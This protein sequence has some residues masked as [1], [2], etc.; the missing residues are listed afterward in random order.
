ML[1]KGIPQRASRVT[2]TVLLVA[3]GLVLG[4]AMSGLVLI[5]L[6]LIALA[7]TGLASRRSPLLR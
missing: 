6:V 7:V 4:V 3:L 5:A 1:I 2:N